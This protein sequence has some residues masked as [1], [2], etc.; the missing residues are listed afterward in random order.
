MATF[1]HIPTGR[2]RELPAHYATAKIAKNYRLVENDEIEVEKVVI[3]HDPSS[4]SR[5]AKRKK[6]EAEEVEIDE[7][8][9]APEEGI[10]LD[11]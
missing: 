8:E 4:L 1:I 5:G 10:D 2:I 7:T 6:E 11:D 3:N 9:D